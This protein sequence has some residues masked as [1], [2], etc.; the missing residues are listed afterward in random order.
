MRRQ[1]TILPL[2][3]LLLLAGGSAA[4]ARGGDPVVIRPHFADARTGS[5]GFIARRHLRR[6]RIALVLSG[7]GARGAA[8]IGVLRVLERYHIPVDFIAATSM[9][10]IVGGLYASGYTVAEIESLAV[11]SP[12]E[13][14][15]SLG[16]ETKRTE[17]FV[18]QKVAGDRSFLT[19]RFQGL[20]PVIPSAVSSGQRLT[21][22]LSART[23]QALYHPVPD[24]DHLKIPFRAVATDLVSGRSVVLGDGS[25]AEA[26]RA[27]ATFPLLF[28]PIEK[29]GMQLVDG[30]LLANIPVDVARTRGCD[31]V[32]VVNSTSSLRPRD[33]IFGAPWQT[34]DQIISIMMNQANT[35][36]LTGANIVITPDV[37]KH[38][39]SDFHGLDTLI[40][41]GETAAERSIP[42]L[43][44]LYD[45]KLAAMRAERDSGR[46]MF[47]GATVAFAGAPPPA[48]LRARI[49]AEAGSG[50]VTAGELQADVEDMYAAGAY[51]DVVAEVSPD[52]GGSRITFRLTQNPV[53]R[54]VEIDGNSLLTRAALAPALS[55]LAGRPLD[56]DSARVAIENLLR[57][58]RAAGYSLARVDTSWFD[59][60]SDRLHVHI[61][62]GVIH[63]LDVQGGVR[64]RDAFVLSE[65]PL[66]AGDVFQIDRA[67]RGITNI[68]STTLFDFVY[69][70]V[71][72]DAGQPV[73]TIRLQERPSQLVR[74]GTRADNERY[75]Q[76]LLDIRDENFQGSG[77]DLGMTIAGGQR[78]VDAE[79]AYRARRLFDSYLTF[80]VGG[81]VRTL[82]S[83]LYTDGP[84]TEQYHWTRDVAGEYRDIRY[85]VDLTFGTQL[86]RLGT[87]T[88]D[89]LLEHVRVK[90]LDRAAAL[91][92][93]ERLA[94]VRLGTIVDTKDRSPFP[95]AGVGLNISYEFALD[96]L[97]STVSYNSLHVMY[98][99]YTTWGG[100]HTFHP[101]F[102][103]GFADRTMPFAQEFRLGGFD[104]FSGTREDDRR[105][106]ELL[107]ANLEYRYFLPIR[108]LFDTYLS[109]RYDLGTINE[110]PEEIKFSTLRHGLG[111]QLAFDTPIGQ[112][113]LGAGKSFFFNRDLPNDPVLQGPLLWYFEIGY[114]F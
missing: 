102:T 10:A 26:L 19:V 11:H 88:L 62:E 96:A 39:S 95:L 91:E 35:S 9:G 20:Q 90:S 71:S 68:A 40:R 53:V 103:M 6:P 32:I 84:Q 86:E 65:F 78:N 98:E 21:D 52:T 64:T 109:V 108:V 16:G 12:W 57:L 63:A 17:L 31:I 89:F 104:S 3:L 8:Q 33:A 87:A 69:L 7:G 85:G 29:N 43:L 83:Y 100:R 101:R 15:L 22:F 67:R 47:T 45:R 24:F 114:R 111:L 48:L 49:A 81:F 59:P 112:A 92:D 72:Y 46:A 42:D 80:G 110:V 54:G 107:L 25:L 106:R 36:Q 82:D 55:P 18:D 79:L 34:A 77:M 30:G 44:A 66:H 14:I 70:E 113:A 105:G 5:P 50:V 58:Y 51:S 41:A 1:R 23:L 37:G 56:A 13:E 60:S 97:G 2:F 4:P 94:L 99:T 28:Q 76:G 74:L 75:L 38:L 73:I 61:N 27:S 93:Q